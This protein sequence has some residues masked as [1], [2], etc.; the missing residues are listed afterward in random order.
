MGNDNEPGPV[1]EAAG[2]LLQFGRL[3]RGRLREFAKDKGQEARQT[4]R[5]V[6]EELDQELRSTD[7]DK[8]AA[9]DKSAKE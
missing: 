1:R 9:P 5:E 7:P 3:V 4:L 2:I 8:G 6:R